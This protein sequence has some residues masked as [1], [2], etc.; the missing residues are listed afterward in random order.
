[1]SS[2]SKIRLIE[3]GA[4]LIHHKGFH[5]TGLQEILQA[6]GV[7]KGSFY[8]YFD[9]KEDFGLAVIDHYD[10]QFALIA[11]SILAGNPQE[12]ALDRL[13]QFLGAFRE[14]FR[15]HDFTRGCPVGNLAQELGDLND[16]FRDRLD[17]SIRDM[18]RPIED[19]LGQ[20]RERGEWKGDAD[21]ESLAFFL[22]SAWH[23]SML[24]M[25]VTRDARPLEIFETL[26][27]EQVLA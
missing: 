14:Y 12:P 24:R 7:P 16:V 23:G 18:A 6:A 11:E 26:L 10:A 2:K 21:I 5:H 8:H 1:M 17:Q 25:K 15:E 3:A 9:S 27:F 4:E 13:R 20:A 19:I 22:I